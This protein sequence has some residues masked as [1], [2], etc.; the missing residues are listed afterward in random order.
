MG[1]ICDRC[2]R[3]MNDRWEIEGMPGQGGNCVECGDDLCAKCAGKWGEAGECE[4]CSMS[5]EDL[6][7][8]LP[9]TIQRKE[10]KN[11]PCPDCKCNVEETA[12]YEQRIY[13]SDDFFN[14]TKKR[15]YEI[16]YVGKYSRGNLLRTERHHSLR[17]ALIEAHKILSKMFQKPREGKNAD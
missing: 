5:L 12:T 3:E 16:V 4:L 17:A 8:T 13:R 15:S 11:M 6:E 2:G 14:G 1:R 7:F 10:K 9:M